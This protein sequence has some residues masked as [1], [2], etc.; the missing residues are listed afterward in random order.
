LKMIN[1][2]ESNMTL[3]MFRLKSI[4]VLCTICSSYG[5]SRIRQIKHHVSVSDC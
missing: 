3:K 2:A 4:S 5:T 1:A